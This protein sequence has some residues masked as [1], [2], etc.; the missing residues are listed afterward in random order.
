MR[1]T[2]DLWF[3][4]YRDNSGEVV[5]TSLV[6]IGFQIIGLVNFQLCQAIPPKAWSAKRVPFLLKSTLEPEIDPPTCNF[7]EVVVV[8]DQMGRERLYFN[9][10][11]SNQ[12]DFMNL[13]TACV[14][15]VE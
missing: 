13:D 8:K 11:H 5:I 10:L 3:I 4:P 1:I 7:N 12:Y 15:F 14:V 9:H 6:N 2:K